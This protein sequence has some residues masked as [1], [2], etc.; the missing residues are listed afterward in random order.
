MPKKLPTILVLDDDKHLLDAIEKMLRH[1]DYEEECCNNA[2][3][4]VEMV[5]KKRYD[6]VLVDYR[7]P[8]N[9]GLW[10]MKHAKLPRKTKALLMT[11]YA[12]RKVIDEMFKQGAC[13]YVIK[14]FDKEEILRHLSFYGNT[15][16]RRS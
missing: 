11:A 14:P 6:F 2:K 5:K 12:N 3:L 15:K 13:G 8:Q 7:M 16:S 9:D 1:S 10:F 4:A